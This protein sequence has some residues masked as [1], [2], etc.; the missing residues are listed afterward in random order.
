VLVSAS[1]CVKR[2]DNGS[3]APARPKT[4]PGR[5]PGVQR[6][7]PHEPNGTPP[8]RTIE[9]HSRR[10]R[11]SAR[12]SDSASDRAAISPSPGGESAD[13][14]SRAATS[15]RSAATA[16]RST[17]RKPRRSG[18][19]AL[20]AQSSAGLLDE[21]L[22][23][24]VGCAHPASHSAMRTI[25][26]SIG[27]QL[28]L[29]V[30]VCCCHERCHPSAVDGLGRCRAHDAQTRGRRLQGVGVSRFRAGVVGP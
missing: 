4:Q 17:C 6:S 29:A 11:I 26:A 14:R 15:A 27:S 1:S 18:A 8:P 2:G 3:W 7:R 30:I 20:H 13:R 9:S 12:C 21:W 24:V 28:W 25:F 5:D 19:F 10:H 16:R 22:A 23:R